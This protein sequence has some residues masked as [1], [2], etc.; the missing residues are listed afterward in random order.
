MIE[1]KDRE[2]FADD[3][4]SDFVRTR[5]GSS[6]FAL[7]R[8][9]TKERFRVSIP[10]SYTQPSDLTELRKMLDVLRTLVKQ[11]KERAFEE[12]MAARD[13]AAKTIDQYQCALINLHA[14]LDNREIHRC[15]ERYKGMDVTFVLAE[16]DST[17]AMRTAF[18]RTWESAGGPYI[19][20]SADEAFRMLAAT[21]TV[22]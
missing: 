16:H 7:W 3:V 2:V 15:I 8:P 19:A 21:E 9:S 5:D 14:N 13:K 10:A 17:P 20:A 12:D 1:L 22:N 6:S 18:R 4:I 11:T